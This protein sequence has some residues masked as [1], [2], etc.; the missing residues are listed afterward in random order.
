MGLRSAQ[1][2]RPVSLIRLDHIV[3]CLATLVLLAGLARIAACAA[4]GT[5]ADPRDA[6]QI[7]LSMTAP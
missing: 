7:A 1:Q 6:D 4:P 5:Q 3:A 2:S